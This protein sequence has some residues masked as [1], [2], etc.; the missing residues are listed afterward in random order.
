[1]TKCKYYI[2]FLSDFT[3]RPSD[4]PLNVIV[5]SGN[6]QAVR[7]KS[8]FKWPRPLWAIWGK[9]HSL[10]LP[11]GLAPPGLVISSGR[12][13]LYQRHTASTEAY[14]VKMAALSSAITRFA[15]LQKLLLSRS[16]ND[17]A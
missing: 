5:Q 12:Q 11:G 9:M 8:C 15:L 6:S 2:F 4:L 16:T 14:S 10:W 13:S 7:Q 1:M 17:D 3:T